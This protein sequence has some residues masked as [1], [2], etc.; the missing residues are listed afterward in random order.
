MTTPSERACLIRSLDADIRRHHEHIDR[1]EEWLRKLEFTENDSFR[2]TDMKMR[3]A[4]RLER[5]IRNWRADVL[6][7]EIHRAD[8]QLIDAGRFL[9]VCMR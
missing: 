7:L 1:W 9:R 6:L 3:E 4:E 2:L 5:N 8:L